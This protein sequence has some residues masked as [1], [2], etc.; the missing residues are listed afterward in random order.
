MGGSKEPPRRTRRL[1]EV[2]KQPPRI[3]YKAGF[4]S[5]KIRGLTANK[6]SKKKWL[7]GN[8]PPW[9]EESVKG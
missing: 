6:I 9:I 5:V 8:E 2:H 7:M 3:Y 1:K 4:I